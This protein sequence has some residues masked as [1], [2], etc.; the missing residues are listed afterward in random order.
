MN[1]GGNEWKFLAKCQSRIMSST[2][3]KSFKSRL[4][5]D[6]KLSKMQILFN[7][8]LN[9]SVSFAHFLKLIR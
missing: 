5:T 6:L 7:S 1:E 4:K 8:A 9:M 2:R 3:L